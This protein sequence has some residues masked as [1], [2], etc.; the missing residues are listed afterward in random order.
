MCNYMAELLHFLQQSHRVGEITI[1][2]NATILPQKKVIHA[3]KKSDAL[4]TLCNYEKLR[5][6][7][8]S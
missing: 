1:T 4:V 5:G 2:T 6:G 8:I 3:L 7:G